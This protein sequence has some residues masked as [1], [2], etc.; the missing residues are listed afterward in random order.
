MATFHGGFRAP[1]VRFPIHLLP[2]GLACANLQR[3]S[4]FA[5]HG[6]ELKIGLKKEMGAFPEEGTF[7]SHVQNATDVR[8]GVTWDTED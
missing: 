8:W 2:P 3:P 4:T 5:L 1:R 7:R 6:E